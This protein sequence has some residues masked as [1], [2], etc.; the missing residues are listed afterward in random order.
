MVNPSSR[1]RPHN[2]WWRSASVPRRWPSPQVRVAAAPQPSAPAAE[3][4]AAARLRRED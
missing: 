1:M 3:P 4:V 2:G